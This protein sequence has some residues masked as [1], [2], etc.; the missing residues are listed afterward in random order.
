MTNVYP[1]EEYS[2]AFG[3]FTENTKFYNP[4]QKYLLIYFPSNE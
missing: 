1:S 4:Q 2:N 3:V